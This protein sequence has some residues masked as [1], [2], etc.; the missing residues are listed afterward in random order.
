MEGILT[1]SKLII[2][3]L[4]NNSNDDE[5]SKIIKYLELIATESE[6]CGNI[7]KNLLLF[8]R[9]SESNFVMND[10]MSILER[11][12]LL[13]NHHLKLNN[14]KL[15]KDFCCSY[16]QFECDKNQIQ[17]AIIAILMNAI[18]SMP[19]GGTIK[20]RA[21]CVNQTVFI[22]I[23]DTGIGIS[24]ENL[25]KIFEPF[26]TTKS[27]GKGTGLELSVTYGIV[28]QHNGSIK[29]E[30]EEGKGTK[31]ILSFPIKHSAEMIE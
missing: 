27:S 30:S 18:E 16:L 2:K 13:I 28:K 24:K 22:T 26:F 7:V 14:I 1:Y 23:E 9:T 29:V 19:D 11:S 17:Q 21:K 31:I 8:S 3:K 25:N 6:R 10:L 4:N 5:K 15:E 20:I 12:I